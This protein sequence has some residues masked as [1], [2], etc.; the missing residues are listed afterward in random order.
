MLFIKRC[1]LIMSLASI[2]YSQVKITDLPDAGFEERIIS[3]VNEIRI[4]DTHEHLVLE[5]D[6]IKEADNLDFTFLFRHYA[7]EDLISASNNKSLVEIIYKSDL[8]LSDR[9]EIFKPYYKAMRSTG[10][11]RVPLIAARELY[12]ISE[13]NESTID[14][15]SSKIRKA[16][17]PGLY[18]GYLKR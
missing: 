16:S 4:I 13:I 12:N 14:E 17:K 1:L 11:G 5:E 10:Y 3:A 9:W 15:L 8:P 2:L 6:R 18:K 7:K